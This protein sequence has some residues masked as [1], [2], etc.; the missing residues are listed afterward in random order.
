MDIQEGWTEREV[1]RRGDKRKG[2]WTEGGGQ[3]RRVD[4]EGRRQRGR[5]T[6]RE[7]D[8]GRWTKREVDGNVAEV[9]AI[10]MNGAKKPAI[11]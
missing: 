4:R 7:V 1:D 11:K 2:R 3:T 8:R 10:M 9:A 5:L 6:K